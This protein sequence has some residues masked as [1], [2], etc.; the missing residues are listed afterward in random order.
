MTFGPVA[1]GHVIA[2]ARTYPVLDQ[3]RVF[4]PFFQSLRKAQ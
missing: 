1:D 3:V 2:A 4:D